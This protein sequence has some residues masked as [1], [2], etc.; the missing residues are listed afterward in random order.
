MSCSGCAERRDLIQRFFAALRAGDDTTAIMSRI[1][2]SSKEDAKALVQ[3][4]SMEN[5]RKVLGLPRR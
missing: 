5:A 2:E 3:L 4:L 1:A